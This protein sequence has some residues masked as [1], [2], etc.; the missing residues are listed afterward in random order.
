MA[1]LS[2]IQGG[3]ISGNVDNDRMFVLYANDAVR[4]CPVFSRGMPFK[5]EITV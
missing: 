3:E 5:Y 2:F 4:R 1:S